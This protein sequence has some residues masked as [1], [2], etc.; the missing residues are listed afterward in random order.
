MTASDLPARPPERARKTS[1]T[2]RPMRRA[3]SPRVHQRGR[4]VGSRHGRRQ[5]RPLQ[6][7]KNDDATFNVALSRARS[8]KDL[9][10]SVRL[11]AVAGEVDRGGG[12]VW[13]AKDK[14]N[15]YICRYNPLEDNFRVYK[16][17]DGKRTSS[18]RQGPRRREVAHA[19]G[20]DGRARRSPATS[21]ARSTSRPRT[22]L[23]GRG[24]DRPLVQ[25]GRP[26]LFR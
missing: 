20:H 17:E 19:A 11:K 21:T 1:G 26:V 13:R 4:P 7:A 24:Q 8:Y 18:R 25:G 16:V 6:K 12:V 2:S 22:R 3:R 14:N 15:Y 10:L 23:P 9:D 5:P